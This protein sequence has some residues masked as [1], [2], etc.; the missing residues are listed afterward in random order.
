ML[1]FFYISRYCSIMIMCKNT[2]INGG[3]FKKKGRVK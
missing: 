3:L 2:V 1:S